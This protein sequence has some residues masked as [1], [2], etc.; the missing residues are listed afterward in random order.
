MFIRV[1]T[2]PNSP[3]KAV[4]IVES[5]R[6]GAKVKQTILRHVGIAEDAAQL[7]KI[8]EIA[9]FV[10]AQLEA[11]H[12]PGLLTAD[13]VVTDIMASKKS[14]EKCPSGEL[15][16]D[17]KQLREVARTVVGIHEV[18]TPRVGFAPARC[19]SSWVLLR[20]GAGLHNMPMHVRCSS[21]LRWRV[22]RSPIASGLPWRP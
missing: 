18:Y 9:E 21:T 3:R 12:P 17:L 11:E 15:I 2:T 19:I 10:K 13:D 1:K 6:A 22:S 8:L 5:V 16:V 14:P 7:V 4:Q 20:C